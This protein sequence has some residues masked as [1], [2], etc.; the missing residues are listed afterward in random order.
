LIIRELTYAPHH[1]HD[2]SGAAGELTAVVSGA[3][4]ILR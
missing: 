3:P 2:L 4:T 1:A